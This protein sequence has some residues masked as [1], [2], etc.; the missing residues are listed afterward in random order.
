VGKRA[1]RELAL[2]PLSYRAIALTFGSCALAWMLYGIAFQV[3]AVATIGNTSG[4]TLQYIAFYTSS[5]LVGYLV[6]FAAGGIGFREGAMIAQSG[7]YELG[8]T[9]PEI[10]LLA[11]LSRVWL[12]VFELLPGLILLALPLKPSTVATE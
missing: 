7:Q 5:Y 10:A 6:F 8:L 4:E 11:V 3:L 9:V 1:G 2:S 12:T